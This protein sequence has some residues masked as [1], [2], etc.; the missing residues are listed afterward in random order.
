MI[1]DVTRASSPGEL[2][3][4]I[5]LLS[6]RAA[7]WDHNAIPRLLRALIITPLPCT[8]PRNHRFS[9]NP[10]SSNIVTPKQRICGL[11]ERDVALREFQANALLHVNIRRFSCRR[12]LC[13]RANIIVSYYPERRRNDCRLIIR[14]TNT[15]RGSFEEE[16]ATRRW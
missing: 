11:R 14:E 9:R 4:S 10:T 16:E 7:D 12:L 8:I 1:S 6:W 5:D 2:L 13:I 15:L 3:S